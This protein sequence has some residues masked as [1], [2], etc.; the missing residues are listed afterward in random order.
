MDNLG[1][2]FGPKSIDLA[3]AKGKKFINC[4]EIPLSRVVGTD[5]EDKVPLE[6]KI[7]ALINEALRMNKIEAKEAVLSLSGRDLIVR[8]FEIPDLPRDEVASAISFEA[9]KYIPFKAEELISDYQV[10][11]DK[12]NRVNTVLFVGIKK[13]TLDK[14]SSIFNQLN[15]R[16]ARMEYSG[17]S[18]SRALNLGGIKEKGVTALL[19]VDGGDGDEINFAVS[20]NGFPLFNRDINLSLGGGEA[21][22]VSEAQGAASLDKLRAEIRV[23]LGYYQRKFPGKKIQKF[24]IFSGQEQ[25]REL[26][27]FLNEAG[28][29][30]KLV[31]FA[32]ITGKPVAYSSGLIKGYGAALNKII[33][34]KVKINLV[35][36]RASAYK[37]GVQVDVASLFRDIKV[38]FRAIIAGVLICLLTFGYWLRKSLP[39]KEELK[40]VIAARVQVNKIDANLTSDELIGVSLEYKRKLGKLDALIRKQ[41]YLTEVMDSIPRSVPDGV[42]LTGLSLVKDKIDNSSRLTLEGMSYLQDS[43]KEFEAVNRFLDNLKQDQVFNKYFTDVSITSIDRRQVDNINATSFSLVCRNY[44]KEK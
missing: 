17:F 24:L 9:R 15:I 44:K 14:Y 22:G 39:L 13:E 41:L 19:C 23:S 6:I 36:I 31:N 5:L 7:V 18:I 12:S 33:P 38:D 34:G 26:E 8:T 11:F 37:A 2:Y 3:V 25:Y 43:D 28:F 42:W 27:T 35:K 40:G 16:M 32:K 21:P 29:A 20:E 30:S 10:E 1:I 4:I